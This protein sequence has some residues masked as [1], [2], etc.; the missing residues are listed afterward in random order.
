MQVKIDEDVITI[1]HE[2]HGIKIN[3]FT[4]DLNNG[5]NTITVQ[6]TVFD[7]AGHITENHSHTYTLPYGY[8]TFRTDGWSTQD[9]ADLDAVQDTIGGEDGFTVIPGQSGSETSTT[10]DNTQDI[11]TI[12]P[13]NKWIQ[14]KMTNDE[15]K[16]AHEVHGIYTK[17]LETDLNDGTNTITF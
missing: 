10:A 12:N 16:I 4:S 17:P 1:A 6:D 9:E 15:I 11:M 8:K 5:T 14:L 2:V 13:F 7:A 3:P